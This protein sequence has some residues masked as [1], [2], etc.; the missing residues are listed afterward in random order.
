MTTSRN[1]DLEL[2]EMAIAME[3]GVHGSVSMEPVTGA[4]NRDPLDHRSLGERLASV[5]P[6][7]SML[8]FDANTDAE[9]VCVTA[10]NGLCGISRHSVV[11]QRMEEELQ[12]Q[13][14]QVMGKDQMIR[15]SST[16]PGPPTGRA[17]GATGSETPCRRSPSGLS[18]AGRVGDS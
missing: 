18:S 2:G 9:L 6:A 14:L 16:V 12:A 10:N 4:K 8:P 5:S 13:L 1:V 3:T 7:D 11:P 15:L 17:G